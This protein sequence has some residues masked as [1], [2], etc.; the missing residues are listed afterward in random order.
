[1]ACAEMHADQRRRDDMR[2][3][4]RRVHDRFLSWIPFHLQAYVLTL[5][6]P[7]S[8]SLSPPLTMKFA[9]AILLLLS[10]AVLGRRLLQDG[11]SAT[12]DRSPGFGPAAFAC[13]PA[14][15]WLGELLSPPVMCQCSH[16][17]EKNIR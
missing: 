16:A 4:W 10:P 3:Q 5:S 9:L 12:R 15:C 7:L 6:F 17:V 8:N 13:Q 11:V 2:W 14:A 1:M